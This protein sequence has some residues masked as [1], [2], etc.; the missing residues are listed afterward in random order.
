MHIRTMHIFDYRFLRE[1]SVSPDI[2]NRI[3]RLEGFNQRTRVLAEGREDLLRNM[4]SIAIIMSSRDSNAIEG[5]RTTDDRLMALLGGGSRPR[6]HP[7]NEILGYGDALRRI[8]AD[9]DGMVLSKATIL[10]LFGIMTSYSST[11]DPHFKRRDNVIIERDREG[12]VTGIHETVP[13]ECTEDAV[14]DMLASFWE[15]RNDERINSLLLIPC[16]IVDFLRIHPFE[17]GNGRMSRLLT[18]LLLYQEGYDIC[19]YVSLESRIN[20]SK[21]RY[22]GALEDSETGWFDNTS[23]YT[24]FIE[25]FLGVLFLSYREYDRRLAS[26]AGRSGKSA[27]VRDL[28]LNVNMPISKMEIATMLP[29]ISESTIEAELRRMLDAGEIVKIGSTRGARY[30]AASRRDDTDGPSAMIRRSDAVLRTRRIAGLRALCLA[31]RAAFF[32]FLLSSLSCF[33]HVSAI[34][35]TSRRLRRRGQIG[36]PSAQALMMRIDD[37]AYISFGHY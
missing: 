16:F 35:N 28:V 26:A 14:D 22:Y 24:P 15:A 11:E 27:A 29:D 25:Y 12:R 32:S 21:N 1:Y 9:H 3:S 6:G 18:A 5:I 37:V 36:D 20:A 8:H 19:R 34:S 17:D 31:S 33:L 23:D 13:S 10:E 2:L 4:E 30:I 7:E